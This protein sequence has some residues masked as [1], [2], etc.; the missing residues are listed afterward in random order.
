MLL[1][2]FA[3]M[4]PALTVAVLISSFLA[5]VFLCRLLLRLLLFLLF[6][7][8]HLLTM[9]LRPGLRFRLAHLALRLRFRFVHLLVP[10]RFRF[11]H[12]LLSLRFCLAYL[13]VPLRLRFSLL[14]LPLR[15][16]V[17]VLGTVFGLLHLLSRLIPGLSLQ[18]LELLLIALHLGPLPV[19]LLPL[20][21]NFLD[22]LSRSGLIAVHAPG[23]VRLPVL[24]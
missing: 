2:R 3:L 20:V 22:L 1:T 17:P 10:L 9:P 19:V 12:L 15:L 18:F 11:V 16:I 23:S 24:A 8:V 13:L 6:L 4:L 5:F 21:A 7:F 14:H